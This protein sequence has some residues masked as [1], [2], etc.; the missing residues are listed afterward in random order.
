MTQVTLPVDVAFGEAGRAW[1]VRKCDNITIII[2]INN[3]S[4][5]ITILV[6]T[7]TK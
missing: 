4:Q 5:M 2:I 1:S 3:A 6:I 7:L